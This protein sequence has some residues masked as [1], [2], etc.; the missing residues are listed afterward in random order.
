MVA[1]AVHTNHSKMPSLS[2]TNQITGCGLPKSP[3]LKHPPTLG[4]SPTSSSTQAPLPSRSPGP[5]SPNSTLPFNV[6]NSR[7]S[8]QF[9]SEVGAKQETKTPPNHMSSGGSHMTLDS[10]QV[11]AGASRV[12][13][14]SSQGGQVNPLDHYRQMISKF[15]QR[16]SGLEWDDPTLPSTVKPPAGSTGD[17]NLPSRP[18][19]VVDMTSNID[20]A[21]PS[22]PATLQRPSSTSSKVL[23][24]KTPSPQISVY[25]GASVTQPPHTSQSVTKT[26][27]P[28]LPLYPSASASHPPVVVTQASTVSASKVPPAPHKSS[29]HSSLGTKRSKS[30]G[31]LSPSEESAPPVPPKTYNAYRYYQDP[32]P[33]TSQ[34]KEKFHK[35]KGTGKKSKSAQKNPPDIQTSQASPQHR[36]KAATLPAMSDGPPPPYASP[37]AS[38]PH[39]HAP[40]EDFA[41]DISVRSESRKGVLAA[42]LD[43]KE[44]K[45]LY[46]A[47]TRPKKAKSHE[48]LPP[49]RRNKSPPGMTN[50]LSNF[51]LFEKIK[52]FK[53]LSTKN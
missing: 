7:L 38:E 32:E 41:E 52:I 47:K 24:Q 39:N 37:K 3:L 34:S 4:K 28:Q 26:P 10:S 36:T 20:F 30:Q 50:C 2:Y 1:N 51:T 11:T 45:L 21:K 16:Q 8:S 19:K 18:P 9:S 46:S 44:N 27:S 35:K 23:S 25:A 29:K 42:S 48:H 15:Q 5:L 13:V 12:S 49:N 6:Q 53:L 17:V 14:S 22:P 33:K 31:R 40:S 43:L